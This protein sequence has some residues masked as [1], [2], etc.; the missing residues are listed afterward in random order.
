MTETPS[1]NNDFM[2]KHDVDEHVKSYSSKNVSSKLLKD[3]E[4]HYNIKLE[5]PGKIKRD[6]KVK[7]IIIKQENEFDKGN[8]SR[9]TNVFLKSHDF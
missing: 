8:F 4:T 2:G 6:A 5:L 9:E 7:K 3:T 1:D